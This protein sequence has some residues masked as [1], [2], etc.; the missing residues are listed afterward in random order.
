M[1]PC[2]WQQ[3][4][5]SFSPEQE[6]VHLRFQFVALQLGSVR[7]VVRMYAMLLQDNRVWIAL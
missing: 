6:M 1:I 7:I 3:A 2:S 5:T 4:H